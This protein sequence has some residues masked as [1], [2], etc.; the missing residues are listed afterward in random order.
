M[1]RLNRTMTSRDSIAAEK[2]KNLFRK[3]SMG[4]GFCIGKGSYRNR[5]VWRDQKGRWR[6]G[7]LLLQRTTNKL[8]RE[9]FL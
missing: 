4:G 6:R 2:N 7:T 5:I 8:Y 3:D 9:R 1:K